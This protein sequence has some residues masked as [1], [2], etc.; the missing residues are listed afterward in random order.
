M[1]VLAELH[2]LQSTF[3]RVASDFKKFL[4]IFTEERKRV[5]IFIFATHTDCH[6]LNIIILRE[7]ERVANFRAVTKGNRRSPIVEFET[8]C[9]NGVDSCPLNL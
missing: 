8:Q 9:C 1:L 5:Q 4:T 2:C 7:N 6:L 3:D